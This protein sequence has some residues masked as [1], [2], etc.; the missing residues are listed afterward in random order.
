MLQIIEF[1]HEQKFQPSAPAY[2]NLCESAPIV[3]TA[4]ATLLH[5]TRNRMVIAHTIETSDES[6]DLCGAVCHAAQ[7]VA[8]ALAFKGRFKDAA[9]VTR[10]VTSQVG[11]PCEFRK[12]CNN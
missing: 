12:P 1:K 3:S 9:T 6:S 11:D 5:A 4:L 7:T 2:I 8:Y 10:I